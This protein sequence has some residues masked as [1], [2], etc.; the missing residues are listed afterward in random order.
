[1][2]AHQAEHW[3]S[4]GGRPLSPAPA[5]SYRLTCRG[6]TVVLSGDTAA[7]PKLEELVRGADLAVLEATLDE[8]AGQT[9]RSRL[10]MTCRDARRLASLAT[11]APLVHRPDGRVLHVANT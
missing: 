8:D 10:H 11:S 1:M 5:V 9:A 4:V 3:H 2:E 6:D 7:S